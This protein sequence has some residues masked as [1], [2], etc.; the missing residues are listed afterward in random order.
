MQKLYE[1]KGRTKYKTLEDSRFE[2]KDKDILYCLSRQLFE[3][4]MCLIFVNIPIPI[5]FTLERH[6]KRML[7]TSNSKISSP[8]EIRFE[9]GKEGLH[10]TLCQLILYCCLSHL[11]LRCKFD[12]VGSNSEIEVRG[13]RKR[14]NVFENQRCSACTWKIRCEWWYPLRLFVE[15]RGRRERKVDSIRFTL[16]TTAMVSTLLL[17]L[18][19]E[20]WSVLEGV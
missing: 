20:Y 11:S 15:V 16:Q 17:I 14:W 5:L 8:C 7:S 9:Y 2:I 3:F 19:A 6:Y 12:L 10:R 13:K 1:G 18:W 4:L